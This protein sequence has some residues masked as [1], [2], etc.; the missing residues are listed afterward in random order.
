TGANLGDTATSG[1][2]SVVDSP[3]AALTVTGMSGS[4]WSCD[5]PTATCTRSDVLAPSTAFPDITV[6]VS[7]DRNARARVTTEAAVSGGSE[8]DTGN[9]DASDLANVIQVPTWPLAVTVTGSGS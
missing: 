7:V 5:V 6:T 8:T 2:V 9:D 1:G 3:P 4:G